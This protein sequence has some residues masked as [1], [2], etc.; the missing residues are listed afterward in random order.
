MEKLKAI[1]VKRLMEKKVVEK[2]KYLGRSLI[3][4]DGT[5]ICSF[6]MYE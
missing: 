6:L 5:G 3:A 4:V 1:L 2:W